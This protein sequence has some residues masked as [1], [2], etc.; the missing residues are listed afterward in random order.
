MRRCLGRI[1][2]GSA[3]FAFVA[4]PATPSLGLEPG[5]Q[6]PFADPI[7]WL[8]PNLSRGDTGAWVSELQRSLRRAG[9]RLY[10]RDGSYGSTT[11][12]AVRVFTKVHGLSDDQGFQARYW[13]LLVDGTPLPGPGGEAHR[14]EIDLSR[15]ILY[16]IEDSKV[17]AVLPV[18]TAN[19]GKYR[20]FFGRIATAR[21]PEGRF[22]LYN[23]RF[24][25]HE[26]YLGML[27]NPFYFIGGYAIH[28]S[29]E[30]PWYPA[31]HGCVRVRIADMIWLMDRL[32]MGIPVYVYGKA[33]A[34]SDVVPSPRL[35]PLEDL[36]GLTADAGIAIA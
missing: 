7:H 10:D 29:P 30:V 3:V 36:L 4:V 14:V 34:R 12:A 20:D 28:G 24:G 32:E 22:E 21:T 2:I 17:T 31:S 13:Q 1:A 11:L 16:L 8:G 9:F 5:S 23:R 19:G 6:P 33:R 15:Q 35:I 18:S 26:S 27:Y 25:W